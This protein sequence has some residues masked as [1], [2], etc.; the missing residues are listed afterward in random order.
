MLHPVPGAGHDYIHLLSETVN[1]ANGSL[2]ITIRMP[3]PAGRGIDPPAVFRYNSGEL[4]ALTDVTQLAWA[5]SQPPS[6]PLGPANGWGS[7]DST[8]LTGSATAWNFTSPGLHPAVNCSYVSAYHFYDINGTAHTLANGAQALGQNADMASTCPSTQAVPSIPILQPELEW[9]YSDGETVAILDPNATSD[10][11]GGKAVPIYVMDAEGNGYS[12]T[13]PEISTQGPNQV[14]IFATGMEDRNGNYLTQSG[15]SGTDT[16]GRAMTLQIVPGAVPG[17]VIY[18]VAGIPNYK[19]TTIPTP[20]H[21]SVTPTAQWVIEDAFYCAAG[22]SIPSNTAT[23]NVIS[24]IELPNNQHYHFIYDQTY[25]TVNEIDYPDGGKVTYTW[26][27]PGGMSQLSAFAA[28]TTQG[29]LISNACFKAYPTPVVQQRQVYDGIKTGP[30]QSQ[31]FSYSTTFDSPSEPTAWLLKTTTVTTTDN[32]I[33]SVNNSF[34]VTYTYV[35]ANQLTPIISNGC[36]GTCNPP[37]EQTVEYFDWG[38]PTTGTPLDKVSKIWNNVTQLACEVHVPNG[39]ATLAYGHWYQYQYGQ[40]SDEQDFDPSSGVTN[41]A[42]Y[43]TPS[44]SNPPANPTR[45]TKIASFTQFTSPLGYPPPPAVPTGP[46][47]TFFRPFIRYVYDHGVMIAES[48]Y[49]YDETALDDALLTT[50]LTNHDDTNFGDS[51]T[52]RGNLTTVTN[53]CLTSGVGCAGNSVTTY[54]YDRTGQVTSMTDSCGQPLTTC[55]D[56]NVLDT[57]HTTHYSHFDNYPNG[58]P[59]SGAN[60]NAYLTI[61]TNPKGVTNSFAYTWTAGELATAID[62]NGNP[63][64]YQYADSLK[65]LTRITYQDGGITLMGYSDAAPNPSVTTCKRLTTAAWSGT[66]AANPPPTG[67]WSVTTAYRDGIGHVVQTDLS[68]DPVSPDLVNTSYDGEGRQLEQSN[69]TRCT[70]TP[71]TMPASCSETT[72]GITSFAYDVMGKTVAQ[73][74]PDGST[75]LSCYNGQASSGVPSPLTPTCNTWAGS[76][77]PGQW[78]DA[79][80]ELG[81]DWQRTTDSF[82]NLIE[83]REPNGTTQSPSMET[84]YQYDALNELV[85]VTQKGQGAGNRVR[86]FLY[87]SL[88]Q[89]VGSLN[90]EQASTA[91]P[92]GLT[93]AGGTTDYTTCYFYDLNGNLSRKTDNRNYSVNYSY[94]SL[95][96][97]EQKAYVDQS[98]N[99]TAPTEGYGYDGNDQNRNPI[100][101]PALRNPTG[102]LTRSINEGDNVGSDYSYDVIGRVLLKAQCLPNECSYTNTKTVATYTVAGDIQTINPISTNS[103][104]V[105]TYAYDDAERLESLVSGWTPDGNRPATL[106]LANS[107]SPSAPSYGPVG[108]MNAQMGIATGQTTPSLTEVRAY[109]DRG[110]ITAD[111]YNA[112]VINAGSATQS[113]GDIVLTPAT[114]PDSSTAQPGSGSIAVA[115][116]EQPPVVIDPCLPHSSCPLT[117]YDA[118]S[119]TAIING[120]QYSVNY[121]ETSTASTLASALATQISGGTLVNAVA[122]GTTITL[123]AKLTGAATNYSLSVSS[124]TNYP[125]YFSNPSFTMSASGSALTGGLN[126]DSGTITATINGCSGTYNWGVS[127]TATTVAVGLRISLNSNCGAILSAT[128]A[129]NAVSLASVGTGSAKNWPIS[130]TAVDA[131]PPSMPF[132]AAIANGMSGGYTSGPN[133]GPAYSYTMPAGGYDAAGNVT[134]VNDSVNGAWNYSYDTLN[135]LSSAT[136]ASGPSAGDYGCWTYDGFGDRTLEAVPSTASCSSPTNRVYANFNTSNQITTSNNSGSPATYTYD[137]A[138]NIKYDGSNYYIYDGAGRQC[139]VYN[140]ASPLPNMTQYIYDG[141]GARAAK[142]TLNW[143][144]QQFEA[145]TTCP[146]PTLANGF[147]LTTQWITGLSGEQL[148]ETSATNGW[149]HTNVFASGGLHVTY[150]GTDAQFDLTDWLGTKQVVSGVSGCLTAWTNMPYGNQITPALTGTIACADGTEHHFTSKER[151]SETGFASGNDYFLARYYGSQTGRFL[152][153]DWSAKEEPIPYSRLDDPQTL[154]LY[155]YVRGNPLSGT[156]ADGHLPVPIICPCSG[157]SQIHLPTAS[158]IK[159]AV[160]N[161]AISIASKAY[162][163]GTIAAA[164]V[165]AVATIAKDEVTG[166]SAAPAAT[167]ASAK[168]PLPDDANVVRGGAGAPGGGNSPEGIAAGT[169]THPSGTTGFSAESAPGASV[170]ELAKRVPNGQVGCCK[171][172]QV[173]AAGGDVIPTAGRSPNHATVTGLTPTKAS[174]LLTPT[175]PNP[176]QVKPQ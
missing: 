24:D 162:E 112:S 49:G 96:R 113:S 94:D 57:N 138:G 174:G 32:K 144:P 147:T 45:E 75:V 134:L 152:S 44:D 20:V 92:P 72:W 154:N 37:V 142:G 36:A 173:R 161:K 164:V 106:F 63:T 99:P 7:A 61:V 52:S 31:I 107:T 110:R 122:N 1:P 43:C 129:N 4:S 130:V 85:G 38:Q 120:I 58:G 40:T 131:N 114:E 176:A 68:S 65:R 141:E 172:G 163:A 59:S 111:A 165:G 80:D 100:T 135:R 90:P 21:Y 159:Q 55:P 6:N 35:P 82:G 9:N 69:P 17:T 156:D 64:Y 98:N 132:F 16:A 145:A 8:P 168:A 157:P 160:L 137:A 54:T 166:N 42:S 5:T 3:A 146:A 22:S 39:K 128:A 88:S 117:I 105:V 89:L 12:F 28:T 175:V 25:G 11:A 56:M 127:D 84:D 93:C 124:S 158:E 91:T 121:S 170:E 15:L 33:N 140:P 13:S 95:N 136:V 171:V 74:H 50:A 29:T 109:D 143:T 66:C 104:I 87:D 2:S 123:T 70:S 151:D 116:A 62:E 60:T 23:I 78:V 133:S 47:L 125:V 101:T 27:F 118:G 79:T 10:L 46:R 102:R 81:N 71:G 34:S 48:Q 169:S 155:D 51:W 153:P 103:S 41:L 126:G 149:N 97:V 18:T 108:L 73:T 119:I 53:Y 139:A 19:V 30:V 148:S 150:S 77:G 83:V 26:G 86:T 167:P 67:D 76:V 14:A 115:G